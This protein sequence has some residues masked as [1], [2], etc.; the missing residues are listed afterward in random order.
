VLL[1]LGLALAS[2][3]ALAQHFTS[4]NL[5][6]LHGFDFDDRYTGANTDSG[7]LTT[8]SFETF[9]ARP[10]GD[11]FLF[12]DLNHGQLLDFVGARRG[13]SNLLYAEWQ[14]RLSLN[15]WREHSSGGVIRDVLIATQFNASDDGFRAT[16]I[17]VGVDFNI[18]GFNVFGSNLYWRNDNFNDATAQLTTFWST[19]LGAQDSGWSSECFIDITGT[20][21]DGTDV[22][23]QPRLLHD[24]G[25]QL[26]SSAG[27]WF[28]GVEW[29][30]HHNDALTTNVPQLMLKWVLP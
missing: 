8:A 3:S 4:S 27:Q 1:G 30:Y 7:S 5:Q 11:S 9:A 29:Y 28:A 21:R 18:P 17:G 23:L 6:L 15:R 13:R 24:I 16:L 2:P 26:G 14:P 22:I 19:N 10:W 12:I 25:R 20:D